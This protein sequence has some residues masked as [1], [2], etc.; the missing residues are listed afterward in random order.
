MKKHS[1]SSVKDVE[2]IVRQLLEK[3]MGVAPALICNN[4]RLVDAGEGFDSLAFAEIQFALEDEFDIELTS[5]HEKDMSLITF[6]DVIK[7]VL[8]QLQKDDEIS[9]QKVSKDQN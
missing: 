5:M 9:L 6:A 7:E 8:Q 3:R 2:M 1:T 4:M